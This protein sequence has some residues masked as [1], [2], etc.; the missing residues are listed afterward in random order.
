MYKINSFSAGSYEM[1]QIN[2]RPHIVTKMVSLEADSVMNGLL[3]PSDV[4]NLSFPQLH[5]LPAP[6]GHPVV[7]DEYVSASNP[8]AI[9]AHNIG[10]I[11]LNP[12]IDSQGRVINELALD[13]NVAEK[14][15]RGK[16]IIRRIKNKDR[17]GV[18][19][20]LTITT[21]EESGSMK[22]RDYSS[23][24]N[25]M[26]FDHVAI[27]LNEEPAGE[28][29]FTLNSNT[30]KLPVSTGDHKPKEEQSMDHTIDIGHLA[31][32]DREIIKTLNADQIL[33]ALNSVVTV[34]EATGI[35]ENAGLSVNKLKEDDIKAY[36]ENKP[37]F[38][39]FMANKKETRENLE[40]ELVKNSEITK[41]EIAGMSDAFLLK[42]LKLSSP[43][44]D[45]SLNGSVT[46]NAQ[47]STDIKLIED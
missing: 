17:V 19:T 44:Q 46:T 25:S 40:A 45:Y 22:G 15:D 24:I 23:K 21:S 32:G 37:A 9:N 42:A 11:V 38:E 36:E 34:E 4:V 30:T 43:K 33:K 5:S 31:K 7:N 10:G 29:T 6:A 26:Q 27:L 8:L 2:N 18:S 28:N 39:S 41:E 35:V 1:R 13:I 16:E 47:H 14:D 12:I 3:Y 20:G